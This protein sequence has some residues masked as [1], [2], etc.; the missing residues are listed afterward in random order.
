MDFKNLISEKDKTFLIENPQVIILLGKPGSGKGSQREFWFEFLR[1]LN[2]H[3]LFTDTGQLF[4][5]A[6]DENKSNPHRAKMS[7]ENVQKIKEIQISGKLQSP[8]LATYMWTNYLMRFYAGTGCL[9]MDGSPR[10]QLEYR[11]IES[12]FINLY[13]IKPKYIFLDIP[14]NISH[15]RLEKRT[16]VDNRV[17]N[18]TEDS[19]NIRLND[20]EKKTLPMIHYV[21]ATAKGR[22]FKID[23]VQEKE[24]VFLESLNLI[25]N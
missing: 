11:N 24:K 21:E 19:R 23:G 9:I 17:E 4:R 3:C 22:F 18:L 10:S 8:T 15:T 2:I 12:L 14:D 7:D 6:F 13:E 16:L 25:L 1:S 20:Y 5:D